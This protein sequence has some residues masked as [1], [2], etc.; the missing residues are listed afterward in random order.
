MS[1]QSRTLSGGQTHKP[2]LRV[3]PQA[4]FR[5][6]MTP[7]ASFGVWSEAAPIYGYHFGLLGEY[8]HKVGGYNSPREGLLWYVGDS[9]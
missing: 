4:N 5:P 3:H 7:Q 2:L 8:V 9:C 1:Y 6:P